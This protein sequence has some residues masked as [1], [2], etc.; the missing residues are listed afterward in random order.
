[1]G[2]ICG[3]ARPR[4]RPRE[5]DAEVALDRAVEVFWRLGYEAADTETLAQAMGVTKPSIYAAFGS[6]EQLF[7]KAL[8]RYG[9]R[10]RDAMCGAFSCAPS[11]R[12][13]IEAF[14]AKVAED[15]SGAQ[16]PSGCLHACVAVQSA[17]AMEP[18]REV[19]AAGFAAR[20]KVLEDFLRAGVARG[21]LPAD[22]PVERRAKLMVD[23]M[24][25][26]ALRARSGA[27]LDELRACAA[28]AAEAVLA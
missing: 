8:Q 5:F 21:E 23:L 26:L 7:V 16:N 14:L 20:D 10:V 18:V 27:G 9:Q 6:K 3:E 17:E 24:H 28:T 19:L 4:G 25:S 2:S 22:F 11:V 12:E 1:M 15:V 13:G